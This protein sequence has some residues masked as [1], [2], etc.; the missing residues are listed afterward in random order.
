MSQ[1]IKLPLNEPFTLA[2]WVEQKTFRPSVFYSGVKRGKADARSA[3][4][5]GAR[6]AL[7]SVSHKSIAA[8]I[9]ALFYLR[10][11]S[12]IFFAVAFFIVNAVKRMSGGA[13]A[14]ILKKY[15]KAVDPFWADVYAS[16]SVPAKMLVILVVAPLFHSCPRNIRAGRF[17][18]AYRVAMSKIVLG[19]ACAS[20]RAEV[21]PTHSEIS[22][23]DVAGKAS[24]TG[25]ALACQGWHTNSFALNS[26]WSPPQPVSCGFSR[27]SLVAA[28][29]HNI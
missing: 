8:L 3:R 27:I 21:A 17:S 4:R 16:S 2:R 15:F 1:L 12:A 7:S 24:A 28:V 22:L 29:E 13:L 6:N 20:E 26:F 25:G 11:P 10:G 19:F 14:H 23:L 18:V 9:E 5:F